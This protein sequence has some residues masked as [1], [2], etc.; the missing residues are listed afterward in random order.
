M[1][2]L[3]K[4]LNIFE[5]FNE[6]YQI[7]D[8]DI[9]LE[10]ILKEARNFT[11]ADAGSIYLKE[12]NKLLIKYSQNDTLQKRIG[13]NKKLIYSTFSIPINNNTISGYVANTGEFVNIEDVYDL[14]ED[15]PYSFNSKY[16]KLSNYRTK[17]IL[18]FPIKIRNEIIGV[19]QLI[20]AKDEKGNIVKFPYDIIPVVMHFADN[21]GIAIERALMTREMILRMVKMAEIHD[22]KE[23]GAHVNRVGAYS[24]EIY[25]QWA[26]KRGINEKKI[27]KNKDILRMAAMLHDV[28]KI[29]ISDKILK[30]PGRLTDEEYEEMKKHTYLG[31]KLF[32]NKWSDFDEASFE[33]SLNHHERWDGKGYPGYVDV[34]T[35]E[36]IKDGGKKEEEIPLFAR[37]V[38]VADVYDALSSKRSYKAA[39]DEEKVKKIFLEERGKQFDPEIVDCLFECYDVIKSIKERYPDE[40]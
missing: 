9:L 13:E 15:V 25:E 6:I 28:G 2:F 36:K 38:S 12:G 32:I 4:F 37:I 8:I 16:D 7:K 5:K 24:V 20:N 19:L 26:K 34:E 23:T 39:W 30:K 21:A 14:P 18:T 1:E 3:D 31:A 22:P 10:R 33:I 40:E 11:N 35:G 29:A 17:S 27:E